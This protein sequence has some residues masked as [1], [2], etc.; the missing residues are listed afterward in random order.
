MS[1]LPISRGQGRARPSYET[2]YWRPHL[3]PSRIAGA[4]PPA[5][6]G[7]E[8]TIPNEIVV[9]DDGSADATAEVIASF[10]VKRVMGPNMGVC[11]NKNRALF[12]LHEVLGC[13][14]VILI[15]DDTYPNVRGWERNWIEAAQRYGHANLAGEW[16]KSQFVRGTGT[17]EDPDRPRRL[18]LARSPAPPDLSDHRRRAVSGSLIADLRS[19]SRGGARTGK[20]GHYPNPAR[21]L[22]LPDRGRHGPGRLEPAAQQRPPRKTSPYGRMPICLIS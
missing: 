7:S 2:R 13:D 5:S 22:R 12:A 3:P 16:F 19:S 18:S 1:L 15:E 6:T 17:V 10:P 11:W 9:A 21:R 14:V 8:T 20:G 4:V